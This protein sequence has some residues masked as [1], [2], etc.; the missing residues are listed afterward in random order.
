MFGTVIRFAVVLCNSKG[1]CEI[2]I[3]FTILLPLETEKPS[4]IFM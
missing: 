1:C 3:F 4:G 2:A